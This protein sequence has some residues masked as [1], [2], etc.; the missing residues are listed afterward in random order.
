MTTTD[1][2]A[3]LTEILGR[4][5]ATTEDA[6]AE[7]QKRW[8]QP[9]TPVPNAD[10]TPSRWFDEGMWVGFVLGAQW[11]SRR[12]DLPLVTKALLAVL[13]LA[14][15]PIYVRAITGNVTT[16][17]NSGPYVTVDSIRRAITEALK[18]AS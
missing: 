15:D 18:E 6:R 4:C 14:D 17:I 8:P 7:A 2:R 1:P 5:E 9:D 13:E 12:T 16:A 11:Q 3:T 10:M